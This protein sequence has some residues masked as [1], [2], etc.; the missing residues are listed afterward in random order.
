[1]SE[2]LNLDPLLKV[3]LSNATLQEIGETS[4]TLAKHKC[5]VKTGK[6]QN[7]IGLIV[8]ES[9]NKI[10]IG[11]DHKVAKFLEYG[12][13]PF[14]RAHGIHDPSN[15]VKD[16]KAKRETGQNPYAQMPFLRPAIF[17]IQNTLENYIP[18]K[19]KMKVKLVI[20]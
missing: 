1:M 18:K 13:V 4:Q 17:E 12:T 15:P 8:D 16:W 9:N 6:V 11:S 14:E 19:I 20:R 3:M 5:P 10:I 2:K 7:S